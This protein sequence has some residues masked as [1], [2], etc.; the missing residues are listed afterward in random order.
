MITER[1]IKMNFVR[2]FIE[3][4]AFTVAYMYIVTKVADKIVSKI[5]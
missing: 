4:M 3:A 1:M 5:K 2:V